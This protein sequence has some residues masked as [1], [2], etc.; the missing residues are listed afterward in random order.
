MGQKASINLRV[1]KLS[2]ASFLT[3][4]M[5]LEINHRKRKKETNITWR[6]N[7]MLLKKPVGQER[8]KKKF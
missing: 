2:Q 4:M 1:Y 5:K 8:N 3:M 7:N 6:L